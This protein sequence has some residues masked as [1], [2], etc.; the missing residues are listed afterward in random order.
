[1]RQIAGYPGSNEQRLAIERGELEGNCGSWSA[2]PQDWVVHGK[3]NP[4]VRF[5]GQGS[6]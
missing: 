2:M 3:F 1:V 4:L 5:L 6:S